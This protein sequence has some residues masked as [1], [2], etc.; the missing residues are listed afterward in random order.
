MDQET[1]RLLSS[2]KQQYVGGDGRH[3]P[4]SPRM[5]LDDPMVDA[6]LKDDV[7]E[8]VIAVR[9]TEHSTA[10]RGTCAASDSDEDLDQSDMDLV[11]ENLRDH[12]R[13]VWHKRPSVFMICVV[14][15]IT[16]FV[17]GI[18]Q[19]QELTL[20]FDG[21]CHYYNSKHPDGMIS[22]GSA[23][24]QQL[25]TR[26]Q[27]WQNLIGGVSTVLVSVKMGHLSDVYGRKPLLVYNILI[28]VVSGCL[29][30]LIF[31]ADEAW[32]T[33]AR[34]L[35][36]HFLGTLAGSLPVTMGLSN[37]Y[38]I[39][40][41]DETQRATYMAIL[42][43]FFYIGLTLGPMT[44]AFVP[45]PMFQIYAL[46]VLVQA[47]ALVLVVLFLPESRSRKLRRRSSRRMSSISASKPAI[48]VGSSLRLLWIT[49][50]DASGNIDWDARWTVVKLLVV[51]VLVFSATMGAGIVWAIYGK[52]KFQWTSRDLSFCLG[53]AML[54]RA[55][56]LLVFNP[57][58]SKKLAYHFRKETTMIDA[59]DKLALLLAV[60][61]NSVG[62]LLMICAASPSLFLASFLF[63]GFGSILDPVLHSTVL[64]YNQAPDRNGELFGCFAL[65]RSTLSVAAP[66]FFLTVYT[67]TLKSDPKVALYITEALMLASLALVLSL[68]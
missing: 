8:D 48:G 17:L 33:P 6:Y 60:S 12:R 16:A 29:K 41:V 49:R 9:Q 37:S 1:D 50:R 65:I 42:V 4:L 40:V 10:E 24:S 19:G 54:C 23:A 35:A 28:F 18:Q 20:T 57:W 27:W 44:G 47:L 30:S 68:R 66:T 52:F 39:D 5:P 67:L 53:L 62:R 7:L 51:E 34:Y 11:L 26:I 21:A 59:T 56:V 46:S 13:L 36:V 31:G 32:F 15:F 63:E 2:P 25:G 58:F 22:C 14:V 43:A 55:S 38:L 64:K 3:G 45:L 61:M